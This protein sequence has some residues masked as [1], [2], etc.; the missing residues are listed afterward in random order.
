MAKQPITPRKTAAP[1]APKRTPW[2]LF[3]GAAALVL[4][5]FGVAVLFRPGGGTASPSSPQGAVGP[6]LT[7]D[8]E[9]IDFG[10]VPVEKIVKATFLLQN[11]GGEPLNILNQPQV[12][13]VE[14]C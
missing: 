6:E 10:E 9:L 3:V 5:I 13:V 4:I 8:R 11:T 14:G 7:V 1:P 2:P 12:R